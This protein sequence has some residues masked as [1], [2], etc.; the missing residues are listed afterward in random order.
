MGKIDL[1]VVEPGYSCVIQNCPDPD[2]IWTPGC[3]DSEEECCTDCVYG[4]T[5][6]AY[7]NYN[8]AA[9][10]DDDS[11]YSDNYVVGCMDTAACNYDENAISVNTLYCRYIAYNGKGSHI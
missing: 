1:Y 6:S 7:D 11:C 10:C 2:Q 9:T 8:P 4:C 3:T 5:D